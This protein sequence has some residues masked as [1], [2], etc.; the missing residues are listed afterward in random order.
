M[1]K[2]TCKGSSSQPA[3]RRATDTAYPEG[4]C[5]ECHDWI[6]LGTSGAMLPHKPLGPL[7]EPARD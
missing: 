5:P 1:T 2:S 4:Y 6:V 7:Q 3:E